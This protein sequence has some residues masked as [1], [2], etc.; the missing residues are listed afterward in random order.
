M[1]ALRNPAGDYQLP[2][3]PFV[4][5]PELTTGLRKRYPVVIVGGGLAGLTAGCDLASR[6]I[7]C[8]LLDEDDTV[9]VRGASSRGICYAQKSLEIFARLGTYPH[10]KDKGITWSVGRTLAGEEEVYSF[11]LQTDSHSLQPPFINLQQFYIEW[12]LVER[13]RELPQCDLRW[14][15]HVTK[16]E[17]RGD[18]ALV[19]VDTPAGSYQL[20]AS[21]LI[22]ASGVNSGIRQAFGLDAHSA[23]APDRWCITDVRFKE[24]FPVERWTWIEAPFNDN[25]CVWQH[26]MADD[27]WRLDYQMDASCDPEYVSRPE[28]AEERLRA[29]L[30]RDVEF[31]LVWVGPYS[32]RD[33]LLDNFR[34]GRVF[35]VGD[36]AHVVSPF[37]ARGG[38]S[39]IQDA[40]NL[41]W[42]L[43][44]VL[45]GQAPEALLDTYHIERHAAAKTNLEVTS[46]TARFLAPRTP[47]ERTLRSAAISL[48][49]E[50]P[51][52]RQLVNTGRMSI[53]N[54][55]P[56]S[57]AVTSGGHSV[58]N[59]PITLP[60][61]SDAGLVDLSREVGTRF[62]GVLF[63]DDQQRLAAFKALEQSYPI[64]VFA[65]GRGGIG[66]PQGK[67]AR[68]T[69]A[70]P[71]AFAL[72]RPDLHLAGTIEKAT[73]AQA[74][75]MLDKALC[76]A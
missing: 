34:H 52:A 1:S 4:P 68:T 8:V 48:A 74:R 19:S 67:L 43:A 12:F 59:V 11:N 5:P 40:D 23:K 61:G 32:Y 38:N 17:E 63:D 6:G 30:G 56:Y 51:F 45:Q 49:R 42:K 65:C 35:F 15:S 2:S 28:V 69:G 25:R 72:I 41:T 55:C 14:K 70:V 46:R 58:Q 47:A 29:H 9:G 62:I 53:A 22:D 66:D 20:E 31:E 24:R 44:L 13:I 76:R 10:I 39:G 73:P 50:Y 26:L 71:G 16:V 18:H 33:H 27:V 3:Y 36:A 54:P 7:D 37:G 60:D 75:A 21:W 64:A 57:P